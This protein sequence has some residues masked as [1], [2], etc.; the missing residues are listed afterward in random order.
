M[1]GRCPRLVRHFQIQP[2]QIE[3][4]MSHRYETINAQAT[5]EDFEFDALEQAVNYRQ[6]LIK[7][8]GPYLRGK[9]L[10]VGAGIGQ[11]SRELTYLKNI[12]AIDAIEPDVRL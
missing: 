10:E 5:N 3:I 2:G 4:R 9:V 8:F 12:K 11:F 6:A 1:A 7:E